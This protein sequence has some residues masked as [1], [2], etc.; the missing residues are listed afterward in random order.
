MFKI[1]QEEGRDNKSESRELDARRD[2]AGWQGR[3]CRNWVTREYRIDEVGS[4][5]RDLVINLGWHCVN[6]RA[7]YTSA[8][9]FPQESIYH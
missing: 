2:E 7:R 6:T 9:S 4:S 1:N 3:N 8:R 5:P